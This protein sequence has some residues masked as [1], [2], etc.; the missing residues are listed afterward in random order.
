MKIYVI[1][2]GCYSDYTIEAV[3]D[4][5]EK[6]EFFKLKYSTEYKEA[7]IEEL[8]TDDYKIEGKPDK[9]YWKVNLY[10]KEKPDARCFLSGKER[11][12]VQGTY[13]H[14][15]ESVVIAKTEEQAI[16]ITRDKYAQY[17][18]EKM[19]RER[20]ALDAVINKE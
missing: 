20:D 2:S 4:D 5:K 1:T 16:K 18:Y 7:Y 3:T 9:L 6:A 19:E 10:K 11:F 8:D 14:L 15:C 17:L 13:G 12:I